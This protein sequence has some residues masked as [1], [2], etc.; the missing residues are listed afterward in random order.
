MKGL[1]TSDYRGQNGYSWPGNEEEDG[2]PLSVQFRLD[3]F[4]C[5]F[6]TDKAMSDLAPL[7]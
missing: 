1:D 7:S 3:L 6:P 2:Y 5:T 4:T